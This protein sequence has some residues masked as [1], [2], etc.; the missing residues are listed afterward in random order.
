MN[1]IT[2]TEIKLQGMEAL[3]AALGEVHAEKFISL[4]L[5]EPFDYTMWQKKLWTDKS[6]EEISSMAMKLRKEMDK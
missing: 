4:I 1:T 5:R 2:D 3:I 6:V